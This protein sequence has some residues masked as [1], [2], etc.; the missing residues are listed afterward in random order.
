MIKLSLFHNLTLPEHQLCW[1]QVQ[2]QP[3]KTSYQQNEKKKPPSNPDQCRRVFL[4]ELPSEVRI[5]KK[6]PTFFLNEKKNQSKTKHSRRE[7][8]KVLSNNY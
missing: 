2:N 3:D 7:T 4:I 8:H 5:I 6:F 1:T